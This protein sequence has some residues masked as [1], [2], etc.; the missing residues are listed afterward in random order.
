MTTGLGRNV[1][2]AGFSLSAQWELIVLPTFQFSMA[3]RFYDVQLTADDGRGACHVRY[4]LATSGPC[5]SSKTIHIVVG[6]LTSCPND[7][8][9]V[10][11][12]SQSSTQVVWSPPVF[13]FAGGDESR[14]PSDFREHQNYFPKDWFESGVLYTVEYSYPTVPKPTVCSFNVSFCILYSHA[15]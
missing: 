10:S 15:K 4:E 14:K 13:A 12:S 7:I 11:S 5:Q 2:A 9:Q 6:R 8:Y 1:A 3:D